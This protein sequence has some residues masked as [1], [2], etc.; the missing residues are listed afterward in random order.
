M[1]FVLKPDVKIVMRNQW[2]LS[3]LVRE[4]TAW[5]KSDCKIVRECKCCQN[6]FNSTLFY[7]N[8]FL[9]TRDHLSH[10]KK[11]RES[12][13]PT[14]W[15]LTVEVT[16]RRKWEK[17]EYALQT[18]SCSKRPVS[19]SR[20][21]SNVNWTNGRE[22]EKFLPSLTE[23]RKEHERKYDYDSSFKSPL[24]ESLVTSF[25]FNIISSDKERKTESLQS[26]R[27]EH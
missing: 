13:S 17:F 1:L 25:I 18:L 22:K 3:L 8:E 9:L 5:I 26:K 20:T 23:K 11:E 10:K 21:L 24:S 15:T 27:E 6:K 4:E 12:Q 7:T 2:K 16:W 19:F 14:K